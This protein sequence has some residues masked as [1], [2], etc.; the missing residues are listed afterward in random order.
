VKANQN[1][2]YTIN[3][4]A[5]TKDECLKMC[6][7]F[8][9]AC[10][11]ATKA[12]ESNH[13]GDDNE[14]SV[15]RARLH[16]ILARLYQGMDVKP[17]GV[18]DTKQKESYGECQSCYDELTD[19]NRIR[20]SAC[21][22]ESHCRACVAGHC[23]AKIS[24]DQVMPWLRCP[25]FRCNLPMT[26]ADLRS[27]DL[28]LDTAEWAL[29]V[30]TLLRCRLARNEHFR[31]CPTSKCLYGFLILQD[32]RAEQHTCPVCRAKHSIKLSDLAPEF[33]QMIADGTMRPCPTCKQLTTKEVGI[34]NA[35]NC[36]K[37][38][39]WWNWSDRSTAKDEASLKAQARANGTLWEKG[40]LQYQQ[41]L[42]KK[43]PQAFKQLL[44]R[45]GIKFDPNYQRGT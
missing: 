34:C 2:T 44:E 24:G 39:A 30:A 31:V 42:Q 5:W 19:E 20:L 21:G 28:L 27:C 17:T 32:A 11:H 41:A 40:E 1:A 4:Q 29:C 6:D 45:N 13:D 12:S 15:V 10:R 14:P 16:D 7:D 8:E 38:G 33:K 26:A 9:F 36:V 35:I 18:P 43:D 37:C 3:E 22:H 25:H 23:K